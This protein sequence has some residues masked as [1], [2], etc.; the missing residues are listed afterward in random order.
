MMAGLPAA[1][2]SCQVPDEGLESAPG[3][4]GAGGNPR[5]A[6]QQPHLQWSGRRPTTAFRTLTA[7]QG[8]LATW[9]AQHH[10]TPPAS[11]G[12]S[13]KGP[14]Q[15]LSEQIFSVVPRNWAEGSRAITAQ[16]G[17]PGFGRGGGWT[18]PS[19]PPGRAL[20]CTSS[21]P[22]LVLLFPSAEG[23]WAPGL[24]PL[25]GDTV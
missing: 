22:R 17:W 8:P 3:G 2:S 20:S 13:R 9:M 19:L 14:S 11:P 5:H 10:R 23:C 15:S 4:M 21:S 12:C 24:P 1:P 18:G 7:S 25:L 16:L 6:L